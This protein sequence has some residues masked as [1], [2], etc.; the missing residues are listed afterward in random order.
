MKGIIINKMKKR[1]IIRFFAFIF[2]I[3]ALTSIAVSAIIDD[4]AYY[5]MERNVPDGEVGDN[6][7]QNPDDTNRGAVDDAMDKASDVVN[8]AK[9]DVKD[10]GE[11]V[12]D[13]VEETVGTKTM[14]IVIAI[15]IAVAIIILIVIMIPKNRDKSNRK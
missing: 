4:S 13:A 3:M 6:S 2:V 11:T 12:K 15:L 7:T 8:D 9:E 1:D 14:G 10:A 5:I